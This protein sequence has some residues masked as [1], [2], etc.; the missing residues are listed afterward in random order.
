MKNIIGKELCNVVISGT[1][2]YTPKESISN[3]ELVNSFNTYVDLYNQKNPDKEPLPYSSA[4]FILKASGIERR[5]TVNK[6][7]ILDIERMRPCIHERP[8]DAYSL[9]CEMSIESAK[10]AMERAAVNRQ[11]ID[12]VLVSCSVIQRAYP[13]IAIEIQQA[14]GIEGFAFDMQAACASATFGIQTAVD[15]ILN[16]NATTILMV[17]PETCTAHLNFR[18]RDSHF[19][20]GDA[21]SAVILQKEECARNKHAF[22]ILGTKLQTQFSNNIR[23]NIGFL[24]PLDPV[25]PD[26]YSKVFTQQ[27]RKVFKEVVPWVSELVSSHLKNLNISGES[28]KRLWLHQANANMNRLI[29]T[30]ILEKEPE[31]LEAPTILNEFGNTSSPGAVIAFH[32]YHEDLNSK[33]IGV[34]CSFGAGYTAG[35]VILEKI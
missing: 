17:N 34:L 28:L 10:E 14:L 21:C 6:A 3:E 15:T 19:I 16:G 18:D 20:F 4:E 31:E 26:T 1:G 5:Y 13:G 35:S 30:K 9:Q 33:D 29:A 27:G 23:N 12:M 24:N 25:N 11:D 22:R 32:R 2:I 7:G 8:D